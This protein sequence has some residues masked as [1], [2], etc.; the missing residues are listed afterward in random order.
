M[1]TLLTHSLPRSSQCQRFRA[2]QAVLLGRSG[3]RLGGL[4]SAAPGC[5]LPHTLKRANGRSACLKL[6]KVNGCFGGRTGRDSR[7][8]PLK[9]VAALKNLVQIFHL[10]SLCW[11]DAATNW[12]HKCLSSHFVWLCQNRW[13]NPP[14]ESECL[15]IVAQL[16]CSTEFLY[17]HRAACKCLEFEWCKNVQN[18]VITFCVAFSK[19]LNLFKRCS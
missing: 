1:H 13:T 9:P 7:R 16:Y 14:A 18:F 17:F 19:V 2:I 8:R 10:I 5:P 11:D 6:D 15:K 4:W 12:S 3:K